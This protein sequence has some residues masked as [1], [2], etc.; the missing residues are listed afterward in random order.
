MKT[1]ISTIFLLSA[2]VGT[3]MLLGSGCS[4]KA[5]MPPDS[6]SS[7][8]D[9]FDSGNTISYPP[10][11]GG[12]GFSQD[13]LPSEGS[14]D[15]T[16]R[17]G[18]YNMG[19]SASEEHKRLH[20]RSTEGLSPV[21]FDFDQ[22]TIRPDMVER[23]IK[24]A[25]HLKEAASIYVVVE[26][27]TDERGTN[28]YNIALAERRAQNAKQYLVSLGVD[29][30]RMRTLSYGEEKPLFPGQDEDSYTQNRRADFVAEQ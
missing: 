28:E 3:L 30:A 27:N 4:K 22:A 5:V 29:P 2:V 14:L 17:S 6:S 1:R 16:T 7:V 23:M 26:G 25:E 8:N 15:D 18:S 21:Y 9:G 10:A 13:N 12:S 19:D 11:E 24:N 20:G